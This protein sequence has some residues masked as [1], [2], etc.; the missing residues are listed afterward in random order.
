MQR[1]TG[2]YRSKSTLATGQC[3][4]TQRDKL[5]CVKSGDL[6]GQV[7]ATPSYASAGNISL[8]ASRCKLWRFQ[9]LEED[10]QDIVVR[11]ICGRSFVQSVVNESVGGRNAG[12][13]MNT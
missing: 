11:G 1:P 10:R 4:V 13:F 7:P 3:V 2:S 12:D 5:R 6:G 9:G 8:S